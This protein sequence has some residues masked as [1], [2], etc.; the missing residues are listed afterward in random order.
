MLLN[1][2]LSVTAKKLHTVT[3]SQII[4]YLIEKTKE[5]KILM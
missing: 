2:T 4:F 3:F 5:I 1:N